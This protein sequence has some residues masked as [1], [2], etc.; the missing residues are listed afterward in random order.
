MF[1]LQI[2]Q[3]RNP[4]RISDGKN[5]QVQHLLNVRK[6]LS[7]V[8]KMVGAYFQCMNNHYKK[9]LNIE[10]SNLFE[11]QITQTRHPLRISDGKKCLSS[12]PKLRKY[13][14]NVL[15][16]GAAHLQYVNSHYASL[17]KKD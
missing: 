15:K 12:A 1:E 5:V 16:I 4:L 8:H 13:L 3:T 11:L 14:K 9:S 10:E 17:N 7:N 6:Y 2:T